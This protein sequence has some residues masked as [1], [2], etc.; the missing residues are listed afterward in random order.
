MTGTLLGGWGMHK[1][2]W[3]ISSQHPETLTNTA[4]CQRAYWITPWELLTCPRI[5][6]RRILQPSSSSHGLL[7]IHGYV[8]EKSSCIMIMKYM[9]SFPWS[10]KNSVSTFWIIWVPL[11]IGCFQVGITK[12]GS[13][14]LLIQGFSNLRSTCGGNKESSGMGATDVVKS[15]GLWQ[16]SS[17]YSSILACSILTGFLFKTFFQGQWKYLLFSTIKHQGKCS[18]MKLLPYCTLSWAQDPSAFHSWFFILSP[19]SGISVTCIGEQSSQTD[20]TISCDSGGM[21]KPRLALQQTQKRLEL[22]DNTPATLP[23]YQHSETVEWNSR[24][25]KFI[26]THEFPGVYYDEPNL[27]DVI[28]KKFLISPRQNKMCKPAENRELISQTIPWIDVDAAISN[29]IQFRLI[30]TSFSSVAHSLADELNNAYLCHSKSCRS[31][32]WLLGSGL[33][34]WAWKAL[35]INYYF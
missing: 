4:A 29:L 15:Q 22:S 33:L 10:F 11:Y 26:L 21:E 27:E 31:A 1:V 2:P 5:V 9:F 16:L 18:L 23:G 19:V 3:S 28:E 14:Y 25:N 7:W 35:I 12:S 17:S 32:T 8:L 13:S 24:Q 20:V 30:P 6:L 34:W